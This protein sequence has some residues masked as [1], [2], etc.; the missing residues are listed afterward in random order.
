MAEKRVLHR[1]LRLR[2]LEEELSR[3]QLEAAVADRDRVAEELAAAA[4]R[5]AL[6]RKGFVAS[7]GDVDTAERT[8][9]IL[10]MEQ[11]RLQRGRIEPRLQAADA[12]I[13][14][15][16]EEFLSRRIGRRQVETLVEREEAEA[17]TENN[18]RAQQMLDD[19]FGRRAPKCAGGPPAGR[20]PL[21]DPLEQPA[22][23]VPLPEPPGGCAPAPGEAPASIK[24][25]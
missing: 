18:R 14:R 9:G 13:V 17:R 11:A 6:G 2:E 7:L 1:L 4:E 10:S 19:W 3:V 22:P 16:R 25:R 21:P 8:G 24:S 5:Q 20:E 15:Q 23:E 12:G